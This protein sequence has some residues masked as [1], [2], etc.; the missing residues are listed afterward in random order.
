MTDGVTQI[1]SLATVAALD[2]QV[3]AASDR[4]QALVVE[5]AAERQRRQV[6]EAKLEAV[7]DAF[8]R[9]HDVLAFVERIA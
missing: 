1:G 6:A 3:S 8:A 2:A 9:L 7:A 5:L 4:V